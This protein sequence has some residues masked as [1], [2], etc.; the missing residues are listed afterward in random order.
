MWAG[1]SSCHISLLLT[2]VFIGGSLPGL[3]LEITAGRG[4]TSNSLNSREFC[5]NLHY[6][7]G[8]SVSVGNYRQAKRNILS[9]MN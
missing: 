8:P 6:V 3:G 2:H 1:L 9:D 7:L 4:L 5:E